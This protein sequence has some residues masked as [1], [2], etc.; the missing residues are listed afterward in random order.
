VIWNNSVTYIL[1][2]YP[3]SEALNANLTIV[4]NYPELVKTNTQDTVNEQPFFTARLLQS[5]TSYATLK[6]VDN[7]SSYISLVRYTPPPNANTINGI[8][9]FFDVV[10]RAVIYLGF[11]LFFFGCQTSCTHFMHNLQKIWLHIFVAALAAPSALRYAFIGFRET[12]DQNIA[13]HPSSWESALPYELYYNTPSYYEEY[14]TDVGFFRNI[15]NIAIAFLILGVVSIIFHFVLGKCDFS[16]NFRDNIFWRHM[17][18][19]FVKRPFFVFNS[20][21]FYQYLSLVLACTLQFT[22]IKNQTNQGAFGGMNAAGAVIAFIIATIYPLI[23]FYYLQKK[24]PEKD[25]EDHDRKI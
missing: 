23:H 10:S 5:D 13:V 12:Q 8:R 1:E 21:V 14:Y 15:Y 22:A 19:T 18:V 9:I 20:I 16:L 3:S 11:A 4:C 6:V 2:S 24:R 7:N 17:R 25:D